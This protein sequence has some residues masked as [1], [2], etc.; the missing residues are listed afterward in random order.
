MTY[1]LE[2]LDPAT[3]AYTRNFDSDFFSF[4]QG[5]TSNQITVATTDNSKVGFYTMALVGRFAPHLYTSAPSHFSVTILHQCYLTTILPSI[6]PSNLTFVMQMTPPAPMIIGFPEW[7]ESLGFCG[8]F[9]Y[10]S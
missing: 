2:T 9:S 8:T 10:S 1:Y 5:G 6:I 7:T 4:V 3:G